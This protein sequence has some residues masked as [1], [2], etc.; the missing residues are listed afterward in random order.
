MSALLI[1]VRI[2]NILNETIKKTEIKTKKPMH[3]WSFDVAHGLKRLMNE[4]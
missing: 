4:S 3:G 2:C 1:I